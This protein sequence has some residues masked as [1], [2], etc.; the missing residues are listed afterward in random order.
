MG[1]NVII[2][3]GLLE[4]QKEVEHLRSEISAI[5]LERD[6]LLYVECVNIENQYMLEL[7]MF[8]Y[9]AYEIQCAILRL[10]RKIEMIQ[11]KINRQEKVVLSSIDVALDKEFEEY[12]KKLEEYMDKV[13]SALER[14][15][16]KLLSADEVKELTKLYRAIVKLL[17]PDLHTDIT[18][19]QMR[20]FNNAVVAYKNGDIESLRVI[21]TMIAEPVLP[22][23]E[24]VLSF[25]VREQ[26]RLSSVIDDLRA[27]IDSI[28]SVYPYTMKEII[29][30]KESIRAKNMEFEEIIAGLNET[31]DFYK[32]RV[33]E[34]LESY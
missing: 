32:Q 17:H 28:K 26:K 22:A 15:K 1:N 13:N 6:Q 31:L 8:E 27:S 12:Q 14:S 4:L 23:N 18:E 16:L 29:S 9:K 2:F 10:K 34:L 3:P 25:L 20:L 11:T 21:H 24:D 5:I 7:G 30:S 33:A 19:V